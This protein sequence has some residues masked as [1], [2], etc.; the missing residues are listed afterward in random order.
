MSPRPCSG[1]DMSCSWTNGFR[2]GGMRQKGT[3]RDDADQHNKQSVSQ[4]PEATRVSVHTEDARSWGAVWRREEGVVITL[5]P[6]RQ[7]RALTL[8]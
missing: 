6:R 5:K 3:R 1:I 8:A 4:A 7:T 2:A